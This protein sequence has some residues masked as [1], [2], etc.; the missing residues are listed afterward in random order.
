MAIAITVTCGPCQAGRECDGNIQLA[1]LGATTANVT[2]AQLQEIN[3][4]VPQF[5]QPVV[6]VAI[7]AG[8]VAN[9]PFAFV[10]MGPVSAGPP[11]Q[12]IGANHANPWGGSV[13]TL[14]CT[15]NGTDGSGAVSDTG[16]C[17]VAV[18]AV[19][20]PL[21]SLGGALQMNATGN[22]INYFFL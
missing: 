6:P 17:N 5:R 20:P 16:Q 7:V 14:Q 10:V 1:N 3:G 8:G 4:L 2:V 9:L 13:L 12:N 18:A 22:G 21:P 11:S 15:A 19:E